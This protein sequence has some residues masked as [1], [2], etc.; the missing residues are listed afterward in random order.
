M[1]T[2]TDL[3]KWAAEHTQKL[4][5][6]LGNRWLHIQGVAERARAICNIFDEN[7]QTYLI[8][9]AYLHDIGYAPELRKTGFHPLDGAYYLLSHDQQRLA[10]L[11]AYHSEAQFEAK[12][13]GLTKELEK[14][15][16]ENSTLADALTYCDMTTGPTGLRI[17]FEERIAD[18]LQRYDEMDIVARAI[19]QA[20]PAL[21]LSVKR[22]REALIP[23]EPGEMRGDLS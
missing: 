15:P 11:V 8:A 10:S 17:T 5:S 13:R 12:L 18:I 20:I 22:I 2:D 23:T 21:T 6:P 4:I 19:R 1:K 3:I 9:A 7:N 16:R 14:I